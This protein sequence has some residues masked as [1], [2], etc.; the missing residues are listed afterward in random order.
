MVSLE[1][2]EQEAYI[3]HPNS[4]HGDRY[5][6]VKM[7]GTDQHSHLNSLYILGGKGRPDGSVSTSKF[8]LGFS[9]SFDGRDVE[10]P[11]ELD[12]VIKSLIFPNGLDPQFT[13]TLN[14]LLVSSVKSELLSLK[15]RQAP[16]VEQPTRRRL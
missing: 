10:Y 3:Y 11:D 7:A 4:Y 5:L 12:M 16:V 1:A 15:T 14:P 2:T 6:K 8:V 13:Q 9:L